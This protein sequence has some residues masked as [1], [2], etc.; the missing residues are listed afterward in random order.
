MSGLCLSPAF[1]QDDAPERIVVLGS[2]IPG[3]DASQQPVISL[4][5]AALSAAGQDDLG[6]ALVWLPVMGGSEFNEDPGTQ[7][8]TSGT[9]SLNL[10][11]LGLG[12]TLVLMN[13]QRQTVASVSAD[14]GTSFVD[15]NALVPDIAIAKVDV[16]KDGASPL[17]GSD[18]VSG[19]VNVITRDTF[20]GFELSAEH[21]APTDYQ[22]SGAQS[23]I[24]ALWG[25][26][27]GGVK[28]TAALSYFTREPLEGYEVPFIV[29]TGLS[30][31]GGPGAYNILAPGG[32]LEVPGT[33][34]DPDCAAAG[35][36]PLVLGADNA[37]GTPGYCRLDYGQFFSALTD[38]SRW[39][40]YG[41]VSADLAGTEV[42][43]R[44]S[45]ATSEVERG[46]S[47]S[48]PNL[49][50]PTISAS[51]P[52]N[53]FG[54]DAIWWGRPLGEQAGAARR[55]FDHDTY[56]IGLSAER[57]VSLWGRD[58]TL[59]GAAT[60]S[61]NELT[62]SITDT[63]AANFNRALQGFGGASCSGTTPGDQAAGCYYFNP[64]GSG[65]L[66]TD[67]SDPRYNNP[68]VLDYI[69]GEDIRTSKADLMVFEAIAA[70][71]AL[72]EL[73]AGPVG[74]AFGVQTRRETL[75]VDH[76]EDFNN[77]DFLFIIGGPDYS[78]ARDSRAIF[79]ELDLP[80][81]QSVSL[82]LAA[83]YEDNE[84]FSSTDPK[85]GLNWVISETTRLR[86]SYAQSFRAPSLHQQVS[87]STTLQSLNIGTQS[88]FRPVRT[89][90]NRDLDPETAQTFT[91]GFLTQL[92]GWDITVDLWRTEVEDLI[93][94]ENAQAII[95]ADLG[96]GTFDDPR[97]ELTN[98]VVTLVRAAFVNAPQVEAQGL[99]L[100]LASP[101]YD[102]GQWGQIT[103]RVDASYLDHFELTDPTTGKTTDAKGQRN[104]TNFA[105]SAPDW[106][107][108]AA[109]N[110]MKDA[111]SASAHV[112]HTSAYD[113]DENKGAEIE[114]WTAF[115]LQL[116]YQ[117]A[118]EGHEASIQLGALNLFDA[119]PSPVKTPLGFDTKLHDPR[120]R[121]GY[122]R[123]NF[124]Y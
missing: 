29:G 103:A 102:L 124:T 5:R 6:D 107:V 110:W 115:D 96:D 98:G 117:L 68:A 19:V 48:L 42:T 95:T 66:V 74:A 32:G 90:G 123:L 70:T 41:A 119:G 78:G 116:G 40:G 81:S 112:R 51:H 20:E 88:L 69:I 18:A 77:D 26:D 89:L 54:R 2:H 67:P 24:A 94:K 37:F 84:G 86:A 38:E 11:G 12:S 4:D 120:G 80:L 43:L 15:M 92:A 97:I 108:S 121:V 50:F 33:V 58:W 72:F 57:D 46:N 22:G 28:A 25:H 56:R 76:G 7:N 118:I 14:D 36:R 55:N 61:R 17:Y 34:I 23:S 52:G 99:D 47:P 93:V 3:V 79:S 53:P 62:A 39:Q 8:D 16:L 83:R 122:I 114:A 59:N 45:G 87:G 60:Y 35:G 71:P 73:P 82:S 75:R 105:R 64:F 65:F 63:L 111:Y 31:L 44:V 113:D 104:F 109:L 27:F 49:N 106:R 13:G 1:A 21:R 85:V 100:A 91:A 9:S 10:R 30:A 101:D